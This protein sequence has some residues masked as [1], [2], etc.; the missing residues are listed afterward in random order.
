MGGVVSVN[1][2]TTALALALMSLSS[3]ALMLCAPVTS[4]VSSGIIEARTRP[5]LLHRLVRC[6]D[7]EKQACKRC[8]EESED[9]EEKRQ[10]LDW[11]RLGGRGGGEHDQSGCSR[12]TK[13][14]RLCCNYSK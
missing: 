6:S 2:V 9:I 13:L 8:N 1:C 3:T 10:T 7:N 5:N 11:T 12:C 14:G 4:C